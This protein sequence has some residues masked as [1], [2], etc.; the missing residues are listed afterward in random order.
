MR[1]GV[2]WKFYGRYGRRSNTASVLSNEQFIDRENME[3]IILTI[4]D[5]VYE[6]LCKK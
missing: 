2:S 1:A 6:N 3:V 4:V 5:I